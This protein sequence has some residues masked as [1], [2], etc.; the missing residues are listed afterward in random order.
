MNAIPCLIL[1]L[2][3]S[4][5]AALPAQ[6]P[7]PAPTPAAQPEAAP[8]AGLTP[9]AAL[10]AACAAERTAVLRG[11]L[12]R[13]ADDLEALEN[14]LIAAGDNSGAARV[15]L[16]RDRVLPSLGLPV[17]G[18]VDADEFAAFETPVDQPPPVLPSAVP[19]DLEGILKS[20]LPSTGDPKPPSPI[21]PDAP[22]PPV[23][24]R[25]S[26]R[27]LKMNSAQLS[28]PYDPSLGYGYWMAGRSA[29]WTLSDL[30]PGSYRLVLRCACDAKDGGGGKV[31][32]KFGSETI[33]AEVAGTGGWKRPRDLE[34]GPFQITESRVDLV[35][36]VSFLTPNST[37]LMDLYG[38][39]VKP[40]TPSP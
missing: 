35:L 4:G 15:R 23:A 21:K 36:G 31:S 11:V 14:S 25:S 30:P 33:I 20:L 10:E 13:Y 22:A 17:T 5:L 26:K 7:A 12:A 39:I 9:L 16:E 1:T 29:T 8:A 24:G 34:I 28:G 27:L 40:A 38:L 6:E 2:L 32:A 18:A 3:C 37:Y 19:G